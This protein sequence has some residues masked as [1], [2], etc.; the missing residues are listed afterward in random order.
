MAADSPSQAWQPLPKTRA[1]CGFEALM[2]LVTEHDRRVED[3][4]GQ[5]L[6]RRADPPY[7]ARHTAQN[8]AAHLAAIGGMSARSQLM[9]GTPLTRR[10]TAAKSPREPGRHG[11]RALNREVSRTAA[12][13]SCSTQL[14]PDRRVQ[15]TGYRFG[16]GD[17]LSSGDRCVCDATIRGDGVQQVLGGAFG[18]RHNPASHTR[19]VHQKS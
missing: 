18:R 11:G 5:A 8:D 15:V 10:G 13:S 4:A 6:V 16:T 9:R 1:R 19:L 3:R 12:A 17:A 14:D 2:S 7:L